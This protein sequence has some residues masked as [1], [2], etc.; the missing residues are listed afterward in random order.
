LLVAQHGDLVLIESRRDSVASS[1]IA[2]AGDQV[3]QMTLGSRL[4][5]ETSDGCTQIV[6]G[7]QHGVAHGTRIVD[8]GGDARTATRAII[9]SHVRRRRSRDAAA[10]PHRRAD[11]TTE[12]C[13]G[14]SQGALDL[15]NTLEMHP[16]TQRQAGAHDLRTTLGLL[17]THGSPT[18]G[19]QHNAD[20]ACRLCMPDPARTYSPG[21]CASPR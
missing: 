5:L 2:C 19:S 10:R 9:S 20:V 17:G 6:P 7:L 21:G 18:L 12:R 15:P 16:L 11:E 8:A 14:R 13:S 1:A 3:E 4:T